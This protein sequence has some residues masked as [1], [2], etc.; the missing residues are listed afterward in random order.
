MVKR[1]LLLQSSILIQF[2]YR[3]RGDRSLRSIAPQS[4]DGEQRRGNPLVSIVALEDTFVFNWLVLR[5]K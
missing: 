2:G 1:N 3:S 4:A 5:I